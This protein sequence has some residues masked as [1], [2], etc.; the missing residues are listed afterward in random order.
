MRNFYVFILF[1][2][3]V[4]GYSQVG[5]GTSDPKAQLDIIA[6][7]SD[8]PANIDGILVPRIEK[9]SMENP[10]KDQHGMLVFLNKSVTGYSSG[11]YFWNAL[12]VKWKSIASDAGG[13]NFHKPGT[14]QSP[15]NISDPIYRESSIGL[16]TDQITSRLQ[17]A[18][19]AG[20]DLSLKK[21][22]EVD[23]A[24][25]AT[26]NLTTYGIVNDNR[27]TTNGNKYGIK[28]NVGGI[29]TGIHYGI[30]NE[31]YQ[32]TGT[33]DIYGI[34][35]RIGRT[36]GARSNNYGIYNEIGSIQGVGNIYGIYSIALG[37]SNSNVYAGYFAGRV[38]IGNTPETDYTLPTARGLEG[39]TMIL[40]STGQ[41]SWANPGYQ[42]YSSTTS[43]TGDFVISDEIGTLRI[44]NQVSG[45]VIPASSTNKG[46]IIRL[47]NWPANS[48]KILVFLGSDDLFDPRSN[49]KILSIKPQQI[50]T[51]QSAG[52]RWI[53]L[54]Q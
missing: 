10:G 32:N 30:F 5:I 23:N 53:L 41:A 7:N 44:N 18:I 19:P 21:G 4:F 28:N 35:N 15:N 13:A 38:G 40:N 2:F 9:F 14:T 46:R 54:D 11:F 34:F 29:G 16:G 49:T 51:I 27:S 24:N 42:N 43:A 48:E 8:N 25:S 3:C 36:F 52:N 39:Q 33:N 37:D 17:I 22:L 47:I 26:D 31:T 12:E 1:H 50:F 6:T 45:L 20:K